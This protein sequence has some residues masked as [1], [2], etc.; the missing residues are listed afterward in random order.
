MRLQV[1]QPGTPLLFRA[2]P[3]VADELLFSS[4][5]KHLKYFRAT[6]FVDCSEE[7][8]GWSE[9]GVGIKLTGKGIAGHRFRRRTSS[10]AKPNAR[11]L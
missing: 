2:A 10:Y 4:K 5:C 9:Q 7:W 3:I 8:L 11:I 1:F 6:R